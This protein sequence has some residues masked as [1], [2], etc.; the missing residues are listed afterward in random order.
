MFD[1]VSSYFL[2]LIK[3]TYF[4]K[5]KDA[6]LIELN[7]ID[8]PKSIDFNK[9]MDSITL[10]KYKGRFYQQDRRIFLKTVFLMLFFSK[11]KIYFAD[12][13]YCINES[14]F[15]KNN[16]RIL[17]EKLNK[18]KKCILEITNERFSFS[19]DIVFVN[20]SNGNF[21]SSPRYNCIAKIPAD[22]VTNLQR[23]DMDNFD[24]D[25]VYTYVDSRDPMWNSDWCRV[26]GNKN[27]EPKRYESHDEL[28]YSLRSVNQ[29][30]PWV[31]NIYIVSNCQP[32]KW[33]NRNSE[34]IFWI[35]HE[36]ILDQ[37]F[38]PTFNSHVIESSIHKIPDLSENF[39]YFNDD[40]FVNKIKHKSD[41]FLFSGVSIMFRENYDWAFWDN[42]PV[43]DVPGYKD[44]IYNAQNL[45]FNKFGYYPRYLMHHT[46]YALLKSVCSEMENIFS[47]EYF[48]TRNSRIRSI[49]DIA[50][51]SF[52]YPHYSL[53]QGK[54]THINVSCMNI[55]PLNYRRFMN[56][57]DSFEFFC[58]NDWYDHDD[59]VNNITDYLNTKFYCKPEWEN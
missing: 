10:F 15:I 58:I 25:I 40:F 20:P 49:T 57:S 12:K 13:V 19:Y 24:V 9:V 2:R 44:A 34:R 59:F 42:L 23:F 4:R 28:K 53:L 50:P 17:L 48:E 56:A 31:R 26:F 33:L 38:L 41:F 35:R 18:Q 55:T 37:D 14:K 7:K 30:M 54:S 1:S 52:L 5:T 6:F 46:P 16:Y 32:P 39:I 43:E 47:K 21:V 11:C 36:S 22:Y 51:L 3:K 45:I 29:Y 8:I 27:I